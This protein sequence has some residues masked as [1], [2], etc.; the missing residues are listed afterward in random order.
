MKRLLL[1]S[2]LAALALCPALAARPVQP[3]TKPVV[4][5]NTQFALD[6]H[7]QLRPRKGNLFYSPFSIST[8]LAMT[9]AG[10][11]GNTLDQM[12]RALHLPPQ[13]ALH[14]GLAALL[15]EVNGGGRKR[16]Y[17]LATANALWGQ[18][19]HP[20]QPDF[21]KLNRDHYGAN[22]HLLDF[23][24]DADGARREINAWVTEQTRG[25]IKN[26]L[27]P[28]TVLPSNRLVLTN[29]IY[30]KGDWD[31]HFKK[32]LTR[33]GNFRVS[34]DKKVKVPMM[35]RR[36]RYGYAEDKQVQV[37]SLPYKGRDLDM[38]VILPRRAD[39]LSDVE[40]A[41]TPAKWAEWTEPLTRG[42]P[43]VNVTFPRFKMTQRIDLRPVLRDMG[44]TDA[45]R[46]G[47]DFS[48]IDGSRSLFLNFVVHKAFVLVNEKGTEAAAATAAG[49]RRVS[50]PRII[51]FRADHPF[52]FVIRDRRSNSILFLGRV[53]S[54]R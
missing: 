4:D 14:P 31:A 27:Q 40:K 34:A 29:A 13:K 36:G 48:G 1:S 5:G 35:Q 46:P 2:A 53:A 33:D 38:V 20:F 45:F 44:M 41:F 47:A 10:A 16:G 9:S 8:A 26:L 28:G 24:N 3:N 43:I 11:R 37:L 7:Q 54:P 42:T 17:Q 39:G 51:E 32:K 6:L 15:K 12:T 52:L 19:G 30:F 49:G 22:L 18:K 23:E 50:R 21:L 25:K